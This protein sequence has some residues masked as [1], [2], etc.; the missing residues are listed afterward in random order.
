[1]DWPKSL[2]ASI[3]ERRC[4]VFLGAGA[5]AGCI[6]PATGMRPP[7]W[8]MLLQEALP[9]VRDPAIP[10]LALGM[11][12]REQYLDA[13]ELIF[14]R[15]EPATART[16]FRQRLAFPKYTPSKI[17]EVMIDL[18]PKI[19]VTT[20]YDEIYDDY[21]MSGGAGD[22][23][24]VRRYY[25][26]NVL[27]DIRSTARVVIKPHGCIT[28][29]SKMV[30]TRSQY[31]I[32]RA[33]HPGFFAVLDSLSLVNTLLF[34]GY[35]LSD[36]DMQLLLESAQLSAPARHPHYAVVASTRHPAISQ[37]IR[38]TYNVSLLEYDARGGDHSQVPAALT[39]LR[40]LVL[41]YRSMY[42]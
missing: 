30:L 31:F 5:S 25:E 41:S 23:Y 29:V 18:D 7:N 33:R 12:A 32:A 17:H 35:G 9:L 37:A 39:E 19:V 27:D 13:A 8:A 10:A 34:I 21:C 6:D 38:N 20:S 28:D 22:G 36:P 24:S 2:V 42:L 16:F 26:D 3:A 15:I 1:M 11:I 40:D 14:P 4:I